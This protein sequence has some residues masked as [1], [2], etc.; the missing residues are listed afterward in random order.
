MYTKYDITTK[1][2]CTWLNPS[3][4]DYL[5]ARSHSIPPDWL[6]FP[7]PE[8]CR[9]WHVS[10]IFTII[11]TSIV[12]WQPLWF[13]MVTIMSCSSSFSY[14]MQSGLNKLVTYYFIILTFRYQRRTAAYPFVCNFFKNCDPSTSTCFPTCKYTL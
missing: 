12:Q 4:K 6:S 3:R 9:R 7:S 11:L 14:N 8:W 13:M 5:Q 1:I 10:G 2:Q